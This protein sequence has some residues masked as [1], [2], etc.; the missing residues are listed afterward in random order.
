M[1][2]DPQGEAG[3]SWNTDPEGEVEKAGHGPQS[4][5]D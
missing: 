5:R 3:Q 2:H 1:G 4:K